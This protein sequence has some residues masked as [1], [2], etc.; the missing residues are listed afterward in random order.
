[1]DVNFKSS[2]YR[3]FKV[4]SH[5]VKKLPSWHSGKGEQGW[6]FVDELFFY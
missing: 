2:N 5:P 4:I 1:V 3:Y 6:L